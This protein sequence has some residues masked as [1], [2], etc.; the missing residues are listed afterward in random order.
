M[1]LED[2]GLDIAP[3][4]RHAYPLLM[5]LH[6]FPYPAA[7]NNEAW[8]DESVFG[9]V[10]DSSWPVGLASGETQVPEWFGPD[11]SQS[12]LWG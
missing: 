11:C 6:L 12:K 3:C 5:T 1:L 2:T 7:Q 9:C 10:C 4:I 8:D